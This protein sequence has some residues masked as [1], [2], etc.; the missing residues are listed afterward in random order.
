MIVPGNKTNYPVILSGIT[1]RSGF[2]IIIFTYMH[3]RIQ[4]LMYFCNQSLT[5]LK[6]ALLPS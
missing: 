6:K 1:V 5:E 3:I 4:N 2:I